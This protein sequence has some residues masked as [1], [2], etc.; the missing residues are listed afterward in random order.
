[1][2]DKLNNRITNLACFSLGVILATL[3]MG[4]GL[5]REFM[6][7]LFGSS[8]ILLVWIAWN[9]VRGIDYMQKNHPDYKG[10]DLFNEDK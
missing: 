2:E 3:M 10:E 9:W 6:W 1:M 4:Y 7:V 5:M 8:I